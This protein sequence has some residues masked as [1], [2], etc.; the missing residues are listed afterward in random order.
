MFELSQEH[1]EWL[2]RRAFQSAPQEAC[3][4]II[5][6]DEDGPRYSIVEIRNICPDPNRGFNMDPFDV[7]NK[8][9][10]G[11]LDYV[12]GVW[13][14]H[15]SGTVHP[16][17]VDQNAIFNGSIKKH[18]AYLIVTKDEVAQYNTESLV[19]Q[20]NSFWMSYAQ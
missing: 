12:V 1:R 13:H 10:P 3:G 4:F 16:S 6:D 9:G 20:D 18:W 2:T 11:G 5:E 15:P 8:L 19:A 7:L 17:K 14:T